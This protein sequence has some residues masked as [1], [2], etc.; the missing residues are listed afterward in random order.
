M[1]CEEADEV[2]KGSSQEGAIKHCRSKYSGETLGRGKIFLNVYLFLRE[3][4]EGQ[5]ERETQNLKQALGS[6]LS[7]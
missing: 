4:G 6:E 3:R 7:A 1:P 2:H 5:R